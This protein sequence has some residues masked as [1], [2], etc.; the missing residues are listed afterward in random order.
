[1]LQRNCEPLQ[2]AYLLNRA[3]KEQNPYIRL[4]LISAFGISG[5][6]FNIHRTLKFFNPLLSETYE[7]VDNKLNLRYFSEQVSHH[8]AISACYCEGDGY[9]YY[10]NSHSSYK[11]HLMKGCLEF[12]PLGRTFINLKNFNETITFT[13]PNSICRNIIMGKMH[14]DNVGKIYVNNQTT[15]D[16]LELELFEETKNER[17][18]LKA[19]AKDIYGNVQL[20]LEGNLYENIIAY[21]NDPITGKEISEKIWERYKIEGNEEERFYFTDF[22]LGLNNLTD[23]LKNILPPSDSRFRPDQRALENQDIELATREKLRLE[24]KQRQRRKENEKNKIKH[25][26][27]YFEETYDDMTGELIYL[28]KGNYFE[29]RKA[30]NFSK[31]LDLY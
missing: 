27:M 23:D 19:E 12:S 20:R 22:V 29:D 9:E 25:K 5:Y 17:G 3:S 18:K 10:N 2:Y 14:L 6:A 13:R 15:G 4:A 21:Y 28:Y 7:Y 26:P 11:F 1:M 8:P 31:F 16:I 24:D 30:K